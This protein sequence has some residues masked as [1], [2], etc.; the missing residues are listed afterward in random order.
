[1]SYNPVVMSFRI[2]GRKSQFLCKFAPEIRNAVMEK[3]CKRILMMVL[4]G[5]VCLLVA[6]THPRARALMDRAQA[7]LRNDPAS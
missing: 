4:A 6:C 7:Q 5:M 2:I 3:R 1:M